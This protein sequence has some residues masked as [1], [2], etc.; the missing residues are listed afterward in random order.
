[1]INRSNTNKNQRLVTGLKW[2]LGGLI[3][4]KLLRPEARDGIREFLSNEMEDY[5]L[6]H[7]IPGRCS[8]CKK[9]GGQ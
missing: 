4:W 2:G 1:M 6:L 5:L 8:L 7:H 3:V 9:L